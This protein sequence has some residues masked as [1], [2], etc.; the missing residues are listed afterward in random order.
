M[1]N[2]ENT[3]LNQ[4]TSKQWW[5]SRRLKYNK[6]LVIAGL[7]AF[8]LYAILGSLL[9]RD[10]FEITL[11]TTA[12]Q[13]LSYLFMMGIANIFYGIGPLVDGLYNRQNDERSRQRLFN[14]G[15]WFFFLL[16]FSIPLLVLVM[17]L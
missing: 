6:G 4:Q 10:Y 17:Y 15:Y 11:I 8:L 14:F 12:F 7:L 3:K 9:I 1:T 13:G 2:L 16:P 5:A